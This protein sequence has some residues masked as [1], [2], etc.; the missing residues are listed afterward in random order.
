MGRMLPKRHLLGAFAALFV[1]CQ[2]R[3]P[4]AR[5][6][7]D[8]LEP[9]NGNGT[10]STAAGA[11]VMNPAL[12]L[13]G[14]F[15]ASQFNKSDPLVFS[16]GHDPHVTGFNIQQV[17]LSFNANVDPYFRGDANLVMT[18][19]GTIEIEEA[20]A[21]TLGLPYDLQAKVG[22][23]FTA[24]GRSNP[25]H[26][27][28]WDFA[29]KP[30]VLGR[31]FGG[32]GLRNP[33]AQV[34]WLSPLPWYSEVIVSAQN[35]TGENAQS[36][37]KDTVHPDQVFRMRSFAEA[38]FLG[39][40]NNFVSLSDDWSMNFGASY[41]RGPNPEYSGSRTHVIGGD[42]FLKYRKEEGL[43]YIG[44]TSEILKRFYDVTPTTQLSDW[45][46]YVQADYRLPGAW[47][48]WH[49]GARYDYTGD[50][51]GI[52]VVT[53]NLVNGVD[54]DTSQRWR[55]S[56]VVTFYPSEFSKLR[57]QYNYDKPQNFSSAQQVVTLQIE[58]L[59]GAHGAHKF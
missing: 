48:R 11:N 4:T 32:D 47:E 29:D 20:Y 50:K 57:A 39:R 37:F 33:G 7:S 2:F 14:L 25:T 58:F 34:S 56:P 36:F 45:G 30:L 18:G 16:G 3:T 13:D 21:T 42:L 17:E 31:F 12:S 38:L 23:F 51:N 53:S 27:H 9:F 15:A 1:L 8:T 43:S 40:L 35:S 54:P 5:A 46:W 22:Q 19:D 28:T 24:F 49:V 41:V 59:M 6:Q 44:I 52:P 26:P 10:G 55:V